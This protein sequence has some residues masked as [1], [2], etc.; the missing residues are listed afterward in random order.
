M[1]KTQGECLQGRHS[2][3]NANCFMAHDDPFMKGRRRKDQRRPG[4][5]KR[6]FAGYSFDC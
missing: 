3:L 2:L 5:A 6:T 4:F 1:L